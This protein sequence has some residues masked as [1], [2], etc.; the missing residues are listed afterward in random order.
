[1]SRA[2]HILAIDQGTTSTRALLFDSE[3]Q[4]IATSSEPLHQS[5]PRPGWV[6]HDPQAIWKAVLATGRAVLRDATSPSIAG[7]G[8]TNQRETIVL[9]DRETG[10]PC[11]PAI[12]WQDRRTE[13]ICQKL[14]D[15][16]LEA[17]IRQ[18]TGLV[19]DPYFSA[20]K[21][22][23]AL[24]ND[25]D[26]AVRASNGE[27]CFGTIDSWLVYRL[28]GG[29]THVT[30][31]TNASRTMLFDIHRGKW[32]PKLLDALEIPPAMMPHVA[33][34]QAT[35][36]HTQPEHFGQPIPILGVAGDQQ[37][38]LVGQ[39]CFEPGF[40][41]ATY[42]T[43][44][45]VLVNT[46]QVAVASDH[47]MLTTIAYR[48]AGETT[49]ALEGSIFM[50]GATIQ[51]L[52]DSLGLFKDAAES[53]AMAAAAD[54]DADVYLVPAFQGLGA[55]DWDAEAR[56]AILGLTRASTPN[57]IVRA[58]LEAVAFQTRDLVD[59]MREDMIAAGLDAP[60]TL[61]VDGGMTANRWLMQTIADTVGLPVEVAQITEITAFGAAV[62]AGLQA[63]VFGSE[64]QI[65]DMWRSARHFEPRLSDDQRDERYAGWRKAVSRVLTN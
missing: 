16:G 39:A 9:W 33:D 11:G 47:R 2:P 46:G 22:A 41:K 14:R 52:R 63:G 48:L 40:I 25:S 12:V 37:A 18:T 50:A 4:V 7:I 6:E 31:A 8:I 58:G 17:H 5:Y 28:T 27:I 57:D 20:T 36:G 55:P 54:P 49:F 51:W 60:T 34:C 45:F 53:E 15:D 3:G 21:I 10:A 24:R 29:A 62:H 56:G 59:A 19:I 61:R 35:F 13:P 42:G 38:A 43:G 1:M 32:D 23:W 65:A 26:L 44:C 64:D 30:D